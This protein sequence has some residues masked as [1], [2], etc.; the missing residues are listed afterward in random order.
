VHVLLIYYAARCRGKV[1]AP[2]KFFLP[3]YSH[4]VTNSNPKGTSINDV[5]LPGGWRFILLL[6]RHNDQFHV[7]RKEIGELV[8]TNNKVLLPHFEPPKFNI[9]LAI[10]VW[11]CRA[12]WLCCEQN[13]NPLT[14]P[15]SNLRRRAVSCESSASLVYAGDYNYS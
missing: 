12:T 7:E 4:N 15:Q 11:Q 5:T 3:P 10:H 8:F 14:V 13:F 2:G 9:A 1:V 6:R